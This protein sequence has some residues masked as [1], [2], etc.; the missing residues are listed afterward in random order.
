ML[1]GLLITTRSLSSCIIWIGSSTTGGSCLCTAWLNRSCRF[2]IVSGV[3]FWWFTVKSPFSIA[4]RFQDFRSISNCLQWLRSCLHNNFQIVLGILEETR[5][6]RWS[7]TF[8]LWHRYGNNNDTVLLFS[9][10]Q[11]MVFNVCFISMTK[12]MLNTVLKVILGCMKIID[13]T[14]GLCSS[15]YFSILM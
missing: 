8:F 5:P 11:I 3:V 4:Y 13:S 12:H 2:T 7:Q 1:P 14:D 15:Q 10:L 9:T 6:K